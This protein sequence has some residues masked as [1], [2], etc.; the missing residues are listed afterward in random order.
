[1]ESSTSSIWKNSDLAALGRELDIWSGFGVS[2]RLWWR[3]DDVAARTPA[4]DR[5]LALA[6]ETG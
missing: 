5:L 6:R 3:D 4:L 1:M 2:P